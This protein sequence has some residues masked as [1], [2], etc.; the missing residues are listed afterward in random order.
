MPQTP[1]PSKLECDWELDTRLSARYTS[2][3]CAIKC[4]I[5]SEL[6]SSFPARPSPPPVVYHLFLSWPLLTSPLPSFYFDWTA[7]LPSPQ[8]PWQAFVCLLS[9]GEPRWGERMRG[10]QRNLFRST[11]GLIEVSFPSYIVASV[12][13]KRRW[14]VE[15][16][17]W[18]SCTDCEEWTRKWFFLSVLMR[19]WS[20]QID[21]TR[22]Q[23]H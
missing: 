18:K 23:L 19:K 2:P 13:R 4:F 6:F 11:D 15:E 8:L 20:D 17:K 16:W 7:R 10:G 22:Y 9:S 14:E 21:Q 1:L 3:D 12:V 5:C